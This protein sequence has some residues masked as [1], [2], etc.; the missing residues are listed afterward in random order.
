VRVHA[1]ATPDGGRYRRYREDNVLL[2]LAMSDGSVASI[3]QAAWDR[4]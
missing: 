4:A 2:T 3:A 1:R